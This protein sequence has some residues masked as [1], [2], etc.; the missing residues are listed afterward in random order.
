MHEAVFGADVE[1]GQQADAGFGGDACFDE[2]KIVAGE[3]DFPPGE[4]FGLPQAVRP[5]DVQAEEGLLFARAVFQVSRAGVEAV[6]D[7]AQTAVWAVSISARS[8][9]LTAR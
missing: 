7:R 6:A 3:D 5:G 1:I 4:L 9:L 8:Y 2:I